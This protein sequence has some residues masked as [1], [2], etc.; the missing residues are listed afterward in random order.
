M[1]KPRVIL[2][3]SQIDRVRAMAAVELPLQTVA[4]QMGMARGTL[5]S[6]LTRQG[7]GEWM[8][9][10][11][12]NRQGAGAGIAQQ[13][14]DKKSRVDAGEIRKLK[15]EQIRPPLVL[16]ESLQAK[17]LMGRYAA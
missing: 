13:G 7:L 15:P 11:F 2:D 9:E 10:A 3:D 5:A 4:R 17:W 1:A 12:P 6:A 14:K 8:A 16:P